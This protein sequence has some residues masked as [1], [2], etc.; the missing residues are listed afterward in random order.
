MTLVVTA[1]NE[2]C[3][4]ITQV[5]VPSEITPVTTF[6]VSKHTLS[7]Y[8]VRS[9]TKEEQLLY[10]S[11]VHPI[12]LLAGGLITSLYFSKEEITLYY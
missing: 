11:T 7:S 3:V 9:T 12:K 4:F 1:G 8:S 10:L 6:G 2:K 5:P